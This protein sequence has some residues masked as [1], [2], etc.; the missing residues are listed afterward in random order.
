M[1]QVAKPQ[2]FIVLFKFLR[3]TQYMPYI[4]IGLLLVAIAIWIVFAKKKFKWAKVLAIILTVLVVITGVLSFTPQIMSAITGRQFRMEGPG[5]MDF[6]TGD[7]EKLRD[8][9]DREDNENDGQQ[10]KNFR[11]RQGEENSGLDIDI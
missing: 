3:Y 1:E 10:F 7:G 9:R 4:A 2:G 6:P 8:F 5:S 11:E